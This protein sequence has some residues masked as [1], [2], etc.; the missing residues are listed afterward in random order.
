ME[1]KF[2]A[3]NTERGTERKEVS[4]NKNLI[5]LFKPHFSDFGWGRVCCLLLQPPCEAGDWQSV[6][7]LHQGVS[8]Q[9]VSRRSSP[10]SP[11]RAE[12]RGNGYRRVPGDNQVRLELCV[13]FKMVTSS[14]GT[15][16]RPRTRH[17][18]VRKD[19]CI[20]SPS[21]TCR[22]TNKK[23]KIIRNN[24]KNFRTWW[25]HWREAKW[26]M[27]TWGTLSPTTGSPRL[28]T[29]EIL[30]P[31]WKKKNLFTHFNSDRYLTG[32]QL[33]SESSVDAYIN[34]L[35]QGCRCVECENLSFHL[36]R[37][38]LT[39]TSSVDCW[40]GND[41]EPVIYHGHTIVSKI[42]FKDVVEACKNYAFS[43]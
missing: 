20:F 23:Y 29:R 9:N 43:K 3:A 41:G 2:H 8:R 24:W 40:D 18:S 10:I 5:F 16:N 12:G 42:L 15:L 26:L 13:V 36:S 31:S 25:V 30:P 17:T 1:A 34:T 7:H 37:I 35:K 14:A 39:L 19:L 11:T 28:T 38:K 32:N 27:K 6:C 22:Q 4:C 21:A 33:N